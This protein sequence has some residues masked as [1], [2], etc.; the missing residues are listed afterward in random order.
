MHPTRAAGDQAS[1]R[2]PSAIEEGVGRAQPLRQLRIAGLPAIV[3]VAQ[4]ALRLGAAVGLES[5]P[6]GEAGTSCQREQGGAGPRRRAG[7][8]LV[9]STA[10][11]W[12]CS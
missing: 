7:V 5:A 3:Q 4:L 11:K 8:D 10:R 2:V 6:D 1:R 9:G 12:T